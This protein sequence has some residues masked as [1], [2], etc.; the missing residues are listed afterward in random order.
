MM[1]DAAGPTRYF[2]YLD[3][4]RMWLRLIRDFVSKYYK[5]N[6]PFLGLPTNT[7][8]NNNVR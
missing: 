2:M 1:D 8:N 4:L 3:I 5:V 7:Q 6:L